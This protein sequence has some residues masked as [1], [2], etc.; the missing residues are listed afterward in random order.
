MK[1]IMTLAALAA[2][3]LLALNAAAQDHSQYQMPMPAA[4]DH[5]QHQMPAM[6]DHTQHQVK[7]KAVPKVKPKPK[8]KP[9]RFTFMVFMV[10]GFCSFHKFHVHVAHRALTR[11]R[12]GL[13]ALALHRALV[14]SRMLFMHVVRAVTVH[15]LLVVTVLVMAVVIV[16]AASGESD[17]RKC[18]QADLEHVLGLHGCLVVG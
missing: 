16:T 11:F 12:I 3:L 10:V 5:S 6:Q 8:A 18:H 7:P 15:V 1:T 9:A 2:G 14:D 13:I 4:Q 17:N